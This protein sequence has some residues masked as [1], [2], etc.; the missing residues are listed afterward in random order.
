MSLYFVNLQIQELERLVDVT[1]LRIDQKKEEIERLVQAKSELLDYQG[2]FQTNEF[3]LKEPELTTTTWHGKLASAFDSFRESDL[4]SSYRE[5][6]QTQLNEV[7]SDI[8]EKINQLKQEISRLED[9]LNSYR[10]QLD[11]L[12]AWKKNLL[13]QRSNAN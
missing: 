2:E 6:Y 11:G 3:R 13:K 4:I 8:D 7:L 9:N 12:Y 10:R 1:K 5:I